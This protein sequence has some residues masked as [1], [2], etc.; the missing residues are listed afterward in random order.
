MLPSQWV[1]LQHLKALGI[2]IS[3]LVQKDYSTTHALS[4]L[5]KSYHGRK[6]YGGQWDEDLDGAIEV[7]E[8]LT[9][10]CGLSEK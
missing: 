4:S 9:R 3:S 10:L 7:Y 6:L 8:A 2:K 5:L 1:S